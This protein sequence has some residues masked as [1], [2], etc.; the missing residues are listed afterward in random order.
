MAQGE[1]RNINNRPPQD[2]ILKTLRHKVGDGF[3]LEVRN[4]TGRSYG[5]YHTC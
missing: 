4:G 5:T 3:L 1:N 2:S